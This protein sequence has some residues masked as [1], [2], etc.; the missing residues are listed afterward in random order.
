MIIQRTPLTTALPFDLTAVKEYSR[1]DANSPEFDAEVSRMASSAAS[2]LEAYAQL[3]LLDQTITVTLERGPGC[4]LFHLP[5]AP[6]LDALSVTVTR[7]GAALDAFA[8]I[9][10]RRP[11]IRFTDGRPCGLVVI[12]YRAGF[13]ETAADLPQD[14]ANAICDQ[15]T[16]TF[17]TRGAGDGKSTGTGM[18]PHMA[19][20]AARYRR[21]TL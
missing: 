9:T 12:E 14:I 1:V 3:A 17:D 2:E 11:A 10:G 20:I 15:A 8:V 16:A 21:V 4:S 7:D 6:L 19:R 18:S 13:G 5:I